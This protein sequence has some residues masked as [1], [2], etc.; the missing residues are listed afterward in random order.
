MCSSD[1]AKFFSV[2]IMS[3]VGRWKSTSRHSQRSASG[4][5]RPLKGVPDGFR[6]R[7]GDWRVLFYEEQGAIVVS[8]VGH[9]HE[10]YD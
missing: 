2:S 9:R 10:V 8:A 6:L 4:N 3:A 1:L 5:L 7:V